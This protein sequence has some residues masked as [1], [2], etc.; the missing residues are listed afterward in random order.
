Q[1]KKWSTDPIRVQDQIFQHLIKS[2]AQTR[3]GKDH[4]FSS[5]RDYSDFKKNV[6]VRDYEGLRRYFDAVAHGE[7]DVLWEGRRAYLANT[8]GTTSGTRY[9][10]ITGA[11]IPN[12]INDARNALLSYI[13][14]TGRADFLDGGLISLSGS[15]ELAENNGLKTGRLSAIVNHHVPPYLRT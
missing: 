11:S 13:H 10:P 5:I 1:T 4:N 7:P 2:A 15:P 9:I 6:P 12:H 8:S 3:F 14:E